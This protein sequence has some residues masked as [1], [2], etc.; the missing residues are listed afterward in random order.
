MAL[1]TVQAST[2]YGGTFYAGCQQNINKCDWWAGYF[3][4]E[5]QSGTK[6]VRPGGSITGVFYFQ[7]RGDECCNWTCRNTYPVSVSCNLF[8]LTQNYIENTNYDCGCDRWEEVQ[9]KGSYS[10]YYNSPCGNYSGTWTATERTEEIIKVT[11]EETPYVGD[12]I[13]LTIQHNESPTNITSSAPANVQVSGNNLIIKSVAGATITVAGNSCSVSFAIKPQYKTQTIM[14]TGPSTAKVNES[15]TLYAT[16]SSG[17]TNFIFSCDSSDVTI[18]GSSFVAKKAGIYTITVLQPGNS[19]WSSAQA[20]YTITVSKKSQTLSW[21][22]PVSG[23][24][25]ETLPMQ[26]TSTGLNNYTY[27]LSDNSL[28][29]IDG[30]N[31]KL[32]KQGTV[33]V[34]VNQAGNDEWE[35]SS[36]VG[37]ITINKKTQV[38]S[39]TGPSSAKVNDN[40]TLTASSNS[41]LT[42]F[43]FTCTSGDVTITGNK[44]TAR[45]AG[46]F[47]IT[48]TQPGNDEWAAVTTTFIISVTKRSQKL[49]Y[50]GPKDGLVKESYNIQ[51]TSTGLTIYTYSLNDSS[52]GTILNGVVTFAKSGVFQITVSQ[53]GNDEW[54]P[55]TVVGTVTVQKKQQVLTFNGPSDFIVGVSANVFAT[56]SVGLTNFSLSSSDNSVVVRGMSV[57]VVRYGTFTLTV[58]EAGNVEYAEATITVSIVCSIDNMA[59]VLVV[60]G[61]V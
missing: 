6:W 56:S 11:Y 16:A 21:K 19:S 50:V 47:T 55:A 53:S 39:G 4:G 13:T 49:T 43:V 38:I 40:V 34:T 33:K 20:T 54:E 15:V 37:T 31:I 58:T 44:F 12:T 30:N 57:L 46:S 14:S 9:V 27:F 7:L 25:N 28:A 1:K 3:G 42:S 23:Y 52:A 24:V 17:L 10:W 36:T 5:N 45:K 48:V 41:G 8:S 59:P 61:G 26:V 2:P 32:L 60:S 29:Q 35:P 18:T 22:S 51:V